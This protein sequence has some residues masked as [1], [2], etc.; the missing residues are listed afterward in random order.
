MKT[1][2]VVPYSSLSKEEAKSCEKLFSEADM[3]LKVN[4]SDQKLL[5]SRM[6]KR[7]YRKNEVLMHQDNPTDR[8][9]LIDSGDIRRSRLEDGKEHTVTYAIKTR[10]I[11]SMRVLE[12]CPNYST[13]KCGSDECKL[14]EMSRSD[15]LSTLQQEPRLSIDVCKGLS[16]ELR[17]GSRTFQTPL[18]E[19]QQ[20][21]NV[22][23]P[24][25]AIAAGIESYYRSSLNAILNARLTGGKMG[26]LLPNMHIQVPTRIAYIVGFKGL[27]QYFESNIDPESYQYPNRVRM[28]TAIAP[29]IIM[30]PISSILEASNAGHMNSEHIA[31]RSM[32]GI[33]PRCGREILYGFGLNQLSDY[34]E[35]RALPYVNFNHVAANA[36]GSIIAGVVSGYLSHVPHNISTLKLMHPQKSYGTLYKEFVNSSVPHAVDERVKSWSSPAARSLTR[37]LF[38]TLCP[39]GVGIRTVLIV[40]SF[41]I[42]NGTINAIQTHA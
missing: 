34:F 12:G 33:V 20:G 42:L 38:A 25:V 8:F 26:E 24:A 17:K 31:R 5:L 37:G 6:Y 21:N 7:I 2:T 16:Q 19:Q 11:G 36:A 18:L 28:A 14:F 29:G 27:R 4:P 10:S 9:C 22:N 13:V 30:T 3:F 40:G 23:Y 32:R 35:E 1:K 41:V 15:L 39:R